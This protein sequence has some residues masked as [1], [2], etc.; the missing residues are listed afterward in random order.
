[1][2]RTVTWNLE[3]ELVQRCS[4]TPPLHK[5]LSDLQLASAFAESHPGTILLLSEPLQPDTT[6]TR[7]TSRDSIHEL[8]PTANSSMALTA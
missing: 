8:P 1:M 5:G 4:L 2:R 7:L 3:L 6:E